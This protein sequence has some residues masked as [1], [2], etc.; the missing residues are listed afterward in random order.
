M[1]KKA[2][3]ACCMAS[4]AVSQAFAAGK[5]E[6]TTHGRLSAGFFGNSS[7]L[8]AHGG[9]LGLNAYVTSNFKLNK[10]WNI[11][12]GA[13]GIWNVWSVLPFNTIAYNSNGD[14]ADL[15]LAYKNKGIK[16]V[17]GR[18]NAD[19]GPTRTRTSSFY[20]GHIQ[21][22]GVQWRPNKGRSAHR[23]WVNYINSFLDNGY[24]PGR[25]GTTLGY[26][27]PYFNTGK[28]KAGGE[29]FMVG[30]DFSLKI[31]KS[32]HNVFLAPWA[33]L[34]TKAPD[35]TTRLAFNPLAQVG[36]EA[37]FRYK[38]S[39]NWHFITR[40]HAAFQ[41]GD[42]QNNNKLSDN[43]LGYLYADQ[44]FK[45][46]RYRTNKKADKY[47]DYSISFGLGVRAVVAETTGYLYAFNDR[48][49]FYGHFLNGGH[50]NAG[51]TWTIYAFGKMD[52][53]LFEAQL[54][55]GGGS[56]S[57]V[58]ITGAWKAYR[59]NRS[60]KEGRSLGFDVGGGY[61]FASGKSAANHGLMVFGKLFY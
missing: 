33:L 17:A 60:G 54:L 50:I 37:L 29:A 4:L 59:Q 36:L 11:G 22:V 13:A 40:G 38:F 34:N 16:V 42:M 9:S 10:H 41:Y 23:L 18:F 49:R 19:V 28:I 56:Y 21:G 53:K 35:G 30:G 43:F 24:L 61:A 39:E 32:E 26:L 44:E 8:S 47:V 7:N 31:G 5:I 14:V 57:E 20:N 52:H 2:S 45:Y 3:V 1:V 25:I 46:M 51:N 55:M 48:T 6:L 15:Y 58:S 12:V 27:N